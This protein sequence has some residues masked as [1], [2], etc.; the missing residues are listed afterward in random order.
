MNKEHGGRFAGA[1]VMQNLRANG[2]V[3]PSNL[4][5]LSKLGLLKLDATTRYGN[6]AYYTMPNATL[7]AAALKRKYA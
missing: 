6:R 1:W 3:P 7:I 4:R 5:T 2:I